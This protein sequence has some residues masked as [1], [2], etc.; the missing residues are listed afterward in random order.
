MRPTPRYTQQSPTRRYSIEEICA[1]VDNGSIMTKPFNDRVR[2]KKILK[3]NAE[4]QHAF[5]LSTPVIRQ[6]RLHFE[7]EK[8]LLKYYSLLKLK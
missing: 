6:K 4:A 8:N 1:M 2:M 3:A 5:G 7:A